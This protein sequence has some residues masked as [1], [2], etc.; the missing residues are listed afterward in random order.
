MKGVKKADLDTQSELTS[1]IAN[2]KTE[3]RLHNGKTVKIGF[4]CWNTQ[5]R[6]DHLLT[7]YEVFK[8][9]LTPINE[10]KEGEEPMY[11]PE[12]QERANRETRRMYAKCAAA[13][14][15]NHP[16]L[17][18]LFWWIKWRML[19]YCAGYNGSDYLAIISEAKKKVTG[20]EYY[21]AMALLMDMM[22]TTTVMTKKEAEA[23]RQ[24]L[25]LAREA[26]SLRNS[27]SS[28]SH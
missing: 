1:I 27:Q 7:K 9:S 4:M 28:G 10:P 8:K 2:E 13:I 11:D 17:N 18:F 26:Q 20:E 25:E 22:T 24:E 21:L 3:V 16:V 12:T 14:L 6:I 23:F 5:D 15:L 19:Y